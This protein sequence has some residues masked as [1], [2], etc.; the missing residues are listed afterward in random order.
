MQSR[1]PRL[2]HR[3][4]LSRDSAS[5]N[6]SSASS[7]GR[8]CAPSHPP[9]CGGWVLVESNSFTQAEFD[10]TSRRT[11]TTGLWRCRLRPV[12]LRSMTSR[13]SFWYASDSHSGNAS[14]WRTGQIQSSPTTCW[15]GSDS[16]GI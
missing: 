5:P 16:I 9:W 6:R 11:T 13:L 14:Q 10:V 15:H 2:P 1:R 3:W 8:L 7:F 4:I 12:T